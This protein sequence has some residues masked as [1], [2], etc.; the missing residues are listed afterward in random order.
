MD[1]AVRTRW[2]KPRQNWPQKS[3]SGEFHSVLFEVPKDGG[4]FEHKVANQ[5]EPEPIHLS[6]QQI[7]GCSC[8][9]VFHP[10]GQQGQPRGTQV[11]E[12][13]TL[14]ITACDAWIYQ[15]VSQHYDRQI[16]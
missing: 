16:Q 2:D 14:K 12:R 10:H 1:N 8:A 4:Q 13:N 3:D 9:P 15:A 7:K 6:K 11:T 5:G